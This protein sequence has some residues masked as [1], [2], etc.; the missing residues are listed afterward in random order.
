MNKYKNYFS[1]QNYSTGD[2]LYQ[3]IVKGLNCS[4]EHIQKYIVPDNKFHGMR[5]NYNYY[6]NDNSLFNPSNWM[7]WLLLLLIIILIYLLY[8]YQSAIPF[9]GLSPESI[10]E[11]FMKYSPGYD[12]GYGY[13]YY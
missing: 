8:V 12:N 10:R 6:N 5:E 1:G 2:L 4:E 7:S 13:N 11:M 3:D 9:S